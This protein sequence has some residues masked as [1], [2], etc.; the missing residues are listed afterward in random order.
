MKLTGQCKKS[1]EKWIYQGTHLDICQVNVEMT[2]LE[3]IEELPESMQYGVLVDYF[4][5][6]SITDNGIKFEPMHFFNSFKNL[7][8]NTEQS[9]ELTIEKLNEIYNDSRSVEAD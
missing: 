5:T 8:N 6:K 7:G 2:V 1:F 9:R 4:E 3:I